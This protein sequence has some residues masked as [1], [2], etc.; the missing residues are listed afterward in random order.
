MNASSTDSSVPRVVPK[1]LVR[2]LLWVEQY[3]ALL[4]FVGAAYYVRLHWNT[5]VHPLGDYVYSDMNG[6]AARADAMFRNFGQPREYHGFYPYGTHM[7]LAALQW[8]AGRTAET[9]PEEMPGI[10]KAVSVAYAQIGALT[11]GYAYMLAQRV[12]RT[13]VVPLAV[14]ALL[15]CYYPLIS[16]G[17]YILSEVPFALGLTAGTY[18]LVAFTQTGRRRDAWQMGVWVALAA[19]I[20]PQ[21][22]LSVLL[23]GVFWLV[24]RKQ[25]PR[26]TLGRWAQ[27]F[28]PVALMLAF[29]SWRLHAH[30]GRFGLISENGAFNRV[31]GACHNEKVT[32]L[33]DLPTRG[34]TH[35]G[36]PPLI[37]LVARA[38]RAPGRWPQANPV[39]DLH[40]EYTGYIG[41][42]EILSSIIADCQAKKTWTMKADYALTNIALLW[43]YNVMWPDSGHGVWRVYAS[44]WGRFVRDVLAVPAMLGMAAVVMGRRALALGLV[45]VHVVA[46]TIV[47]AVYFGGMRGRTPYDPIV[48]LIA[49]EVYAC[50][51]WWLGRR[52]YAWWRARRA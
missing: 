7:L 50:S 16:L 2:V 9:R 43:R 23:I 3:A 21:V 40:I 18:H 39:S 45:A 28:V 12:S 6:Y 14:G 8:L 38:K 4:A 11:V 48:I 29:S 31:F 52:G 44:K 36:P 1:L 24:W 5:H 47:A 17:G 33:P 22:L 32:A 27:A 13:R 10:L 19:T 49:F 46:L 34:K 35:F 20:R 30:T 26:A 51:A 42:R 41:D 37:Q 15:V 25:M